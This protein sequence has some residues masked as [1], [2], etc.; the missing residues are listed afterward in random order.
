[1]SVSGFRRKLVESKLLMDFQ[2]AALLRM[3]DDESLFPDVKAEVEADEGDGDDD[4][5]VSREVAAKLVDHVLWRA[6]GQ[7]L[8]S[9]PPTDQLNIEFALREL[10]L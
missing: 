4:G 5:T 10:A 2:R 1:M 6:M 8:D 3:M 9:L 7:R